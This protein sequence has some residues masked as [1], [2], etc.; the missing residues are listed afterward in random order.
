MTEI[1]KS[2]IIGIIGKPNVGK[3]TLLNQLLGYKVSITTRKPQTT[4]HRIHGI[5]TVGDSQMIFADT[6]GLHNNEKKA[7]NRYL[8]RAAS[9]VI[10]DVDVIVFLVSAKR[11]TEEDDFVLEKLED[12][13]QPVILVVNKIDYVPQRE[14]LLPVL[15]QYGKK[16][17]FQTII[18]LSAL[19]GDNVKHL[20]SYLLAQLPEGPAFY[21][22]DQVSDKSERFH[23]AELIRE[24]L[25]RSLGKELPYSL[26]VEI[27]EFKMEKKMR[28]IRAIIWVERD[29]QKAIVI[30]KRGEGLKNVGSQARKDMEDWFGQKVFLGLWVK[31]KE[32]WSDDERA[33]QSLGYQTLE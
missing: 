8:N 17:A 33:L 12:V 11:W 18:P 24:K 7:M 28:K 22:E 29:S 26:T 13:K 27:E 1:K 9:G 21:P 23:A 32:N 15:E 30:G 19:K 6:P 10:F 5:K 2:G 20:E 14:E 16:R 31:T 4:R 25:T 3:S